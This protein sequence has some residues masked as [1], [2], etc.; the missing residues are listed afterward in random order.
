[1]MA[2]PLDSAFHWLNW[3]N[4][5]YVGGAALTVTAAMYVLYENRA[6]AAGKR[7]KF[8]L[9]SE[10]IAAFA[11]IV[12]LIGTIG[13]IHYS[14]VVSHIK[15]VDLNTYKTQAGVQIA[16]ANQAAAEANR[17]AQEANDKAVQ[18][19][20]LNLKLQAKV[21]TE[22]TRAAT[23]E[24]GLEKS[25]KETSDFAHSLQQQQATMAE[26]AKVSPQLTP[27]QI[28][29]LANVLKPFAGQDVA[30]HVTTD[31]VVARLGSTIAVALNQA[32]VTTKSYSTDMGALYQGVSV[33]V[34]DPNDVP[35]IANALVIGLRQAGIN[36]QP[37]AAPKMVKAGEVGIFLGPN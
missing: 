26:Q 19:T 32:G 24:A 18:A 15:D 17:K 30:L 35:P 3:S 16:Q 36:V 10:F 34:H 11:A 28:Q 33:A 29:N 7:V 14:N 8:Y 37:V 2:S 27:Y 4:V 12:S 1:M 25:N 31:T 20:N 22:S 21:A 6:V 9:L 13:A 23:A 5:L